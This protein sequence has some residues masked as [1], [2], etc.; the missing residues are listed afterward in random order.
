MLDIEKLSYWEKKAF[1]T[2]VDYLIIGAGIVGY[3]TA[4]ELR[5]LHSSAKI[6]ILERGNLPT[7]ASSK[8]AG[9]ACF[10]SATELIDDLETIPEHEVWETVKLRWH[11]LQNLRSLIG[12]KE[13]G[14]EIHGSWDLISDTKSTLYQKT[15]SKLDYL[16]QQIELITGEKDVYFIDSSVSSKFEFNQIETSIFNR[17]EG[18]IDTAKMNSSFFRKVIA[19]NIHVLF[20]YDAKKIERSSNLVEIE[21][22]Y[23][24][25]ESKKVAVCTNG[26][27]K[28]FLPQEDIQPARAQV[29]VT[30]PILDLK[31]KGTF[32]YQQGYYYFRNIDNRILFGGGRN[33]DLK[34]ET[35][36]EIRNT[37]VII[38]QLK[39]LLQTVILPNQSVEVDMKWSGIMGVGTTKK[40]IIKEISSG[41]YCGIRLGGMGVAIGSLVGKELANLMK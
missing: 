20:G 21:T 32:H 9:F 24:K 10:G 11:G 35:T 38:N 2:E 8:N 12:D 14:L 6:I 37:E 19:A 36:T 40:P 41:V 3:S 4:L 29:I 33:L 22:N 30:K 39:K 23:G 31:I 27:A 16:N 15:V 28:H 26:F 25:I 18:Q 17:L 34:G 1:F 13:L 5:K 7:G